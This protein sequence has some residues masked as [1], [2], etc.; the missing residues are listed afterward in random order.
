MQTSQTR[1]NPSVLVRI[2][3][4]IRVLVKQRKMLYTPNLGFLDHR[5]VLLAWNIAPRLRE[6]PW[7]D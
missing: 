6:C 4:S 3:E 5:K 1:D 7:R 2:S